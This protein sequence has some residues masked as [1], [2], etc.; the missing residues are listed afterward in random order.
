[1]FTYDKTLFMMELHRLQELPDRVDEPRPDLTQSGPVG[2]LSDSIME[3]HVT[4]ENH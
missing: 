2:L 4:L 3:Q 1:M